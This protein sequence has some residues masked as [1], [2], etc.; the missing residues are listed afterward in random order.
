M[1]FAENIKSLPGVS[2]LAAIN[3]QDG[4]TVVATIEHKSGQIGSL[5]VYNHLGQIY[6]AI[7]PQAA[8][9][10]LEIFAEHADDARAN[11]GKHPN[12]DRLFRL[13]EEGR[14][15]RVKHVFA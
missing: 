15:L 4:E 8:A 2:H 9:K 1:G 3:L 11:P 12:I 7:T 5:A 10:G 14:T 13:I 6:G